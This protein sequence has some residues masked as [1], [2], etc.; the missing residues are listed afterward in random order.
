MCPLE[1]PLSPSLTRGFSMAK[2]ITDSP[3]P[4]HSSPHLSISI[5]L[6]I[7]LAPSHCVQCFLAS[8]SILPFL[9]YI[10][11]IASILL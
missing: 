10:L 11:D 2:V 8:L 1:F 7:Y 4:M 9:R 6:S 5:F 3:F